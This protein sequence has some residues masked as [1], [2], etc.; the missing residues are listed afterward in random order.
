MQRTTQNKLL[1]RQRI[2]LPVMAGIVVL[3]FAAC[4]GGS[5]P[6]GDVSSASAEGDA[7]VV[8]TDD[9]KFEPDTLDAPPGEEVTVEVRNEDD[10][11]HD[12]A[13]EE[14]DLNTGTIEPGSVA[15]ATFEVPE[16]ETEFVCTI[17]PGMKGTIAPR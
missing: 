14:F 2:R 1:G 3:V 10:T 17:H 13:I 7:I 9:N 11:A 6:S 8:V 16:E 15:T 12:F 5:D 4:G